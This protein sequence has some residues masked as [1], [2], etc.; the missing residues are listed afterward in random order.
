[1]FAEMDKGDT[2]KEDRNLSF[3]TLL[4]SGCIVAVVVSLSRPQ[5]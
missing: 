1:V 4:V 5:A 2:M 3:R